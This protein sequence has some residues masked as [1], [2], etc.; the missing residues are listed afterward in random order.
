MKV[1]IVILLISLGVANC[2]IEGLLKQDEPLKHE[3][4][5]QFSF[6]SV[7]NGWGT[8]TT[9][10]IIKVDGVN[11]ILSINMHYKLRDTYENMTYIYSAPHNQVYWYFPG[12]PYSE[13]SCYKRSGL[14]PYTGIG[15]MIEEFSANEVVVD[16]F[17]KDGHHIVRSE[18][19]VGGVSDFRIV[20][21]DGEIVLLAKGSGEEWQVFDVNEDGIISESF[22]VGDMVPEKCQNI[23]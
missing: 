22:E 23:E 10:Y 11:D 2:A 20:R 3:Y 6:K 21:S 14:T 17:E 19:S 18:T 16:E 4:P 7:D 12:K 9:S 15:K 8:P 1:S 13:D 5:K